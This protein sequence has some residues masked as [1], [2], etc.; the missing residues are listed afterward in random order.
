MAY[1]IGT[2]DG[3]I[4]L[5]D[6]VRQFV[7]DPVHMGDQAWETMR[8]DPA[9]E[10][11]LK[12]PGLEGEDEI[13][14]GMKEL[15]NTA[16]DYFNWQLAGFT[17]Y[18]EGEEFTAQPGISSR[19]Q[20]GLWNNAIPYWLVANGQRIVLAARVSAVYQVAYLGFIN[21]YATKEQYPYP[22]FVGGTMNGT[23]RWSDT[24]INHHVCWWSSEN[25]PTAYLRTVNGTWKRFGARTSSDNNW[26]TGSRCIWPYNAYMENIRQCVGDDSYPV[27]PIMFYS[28]WST[29]S[30]PGT[31][32]REVHGEA[33]GCFATTGFNLSPEDVFTIDGDEYVAFPDAFRTG[34]NQFFALKL[35]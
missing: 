33:D 15:S 1:Q 14:V 17:A 10:L 32:E 25:S 26:Y 20:V 16:S 31:D 11:I 5:M 18:V 3:H 30:D 12:G 2:A 6:K 28:N 13:Y 22:L 4:D 27:F 8:W 29:T 19:P 23:R 24:T 35:E 21:R 7:T 9:G 34:K